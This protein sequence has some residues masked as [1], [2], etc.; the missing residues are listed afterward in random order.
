M[1]NN[2][3]HNYVYNNTNFS[4]NLDSSMPFYIQF[5]TYKLDNFKKHNKRGISKNAVEDL[6]GDEINELLTD[7][8]KVYILSKWKYGKC[9]KLNEE[10]HAD[11]YILFGKNVSWIQSFILGLLML[12]FH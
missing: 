10:S 2:N 12:A 8:N 11:G 3:L 9:F 5:L 1:Y 6:F 4:Y 7:K